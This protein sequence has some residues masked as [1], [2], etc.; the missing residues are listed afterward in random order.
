M[1]YNCTSGCTRINYWSN[2]DKTYNGDV[3][4]TTSKSDNARALNLTSPAMANFRTGVVIPPEVTAL[5]NN[6]AIAING[7]KGSEISYSFSVPAGASNISIATSGGTGDADIYVKLGST[8]S[9]ANFD[10]RP[11]ESGNI[12][13]C[14][15]TQSGEYSI[16]VAGYAAYN[17]VSLV[18]SYQLGGT[19]LPIVITKT[20]LSDVKS[21]WK[22]YTVEAPANA[23]SISAVLSGGAGDADIYIRK[24]AQPT[25]S[26]YDC[27]SWNT[28]NS[29]SCEKA[30][31]AE[32]TW[33]VGINA[34]AAYSAANL[35]ITVK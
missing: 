25:T 26:T 33:Y 16:M 7:T 28:G 1:A 24:G 12:E 21:G 29:E 15:L 35:E 19:S 31:T 17:N 4:G 10:C 14:P 20:D 8:A 6:Q 18:G 5:D 34:Y 13:S 22:Y 9:T 23:T 30:V 3:M 32:S 11:Y 2:P 27:R